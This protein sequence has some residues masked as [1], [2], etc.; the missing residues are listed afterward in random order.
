MVQT[1]S[2]TVGHTQ[3]VHLTAISPNQKYQQVCTIYWECEEENRNIEAHNIHDVE[4]VG[5][6]I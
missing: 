1:R 6:K 5:L 3:D 2:G 4:L